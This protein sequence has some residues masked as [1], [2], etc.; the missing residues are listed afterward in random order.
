MDSV[1]GLSFKKELP[2]IIMKTLL[3]TT[4]KAAASYGINKSLA[5]QDEVVGIF[6]QIITSLAQAAVNIADTRTW[7]TLPKEFQFCRIPTPDDGKI[8]ISAPSGQKAEIQ[9]EPNVPNLVCVRSI[10]AAS[11]LIINRV[12]LK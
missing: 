7:T 9:V 12:K 1:V 2:T 4:I 10:N 5:K 3:S 8:V 6:S 11:P